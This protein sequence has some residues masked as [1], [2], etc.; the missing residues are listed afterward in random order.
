MHVTDSGYKTLGP[1]YSC[2]VTIFET[3]IVPGQSLRFFFLVCTPFF[4]NINS[5]Q[6][7]DTKRERKKK[8]KIPL[9]LNAAN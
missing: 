7:K 4:L 6:A 9:T 5:F 8:E 1:P 2:H 3:L